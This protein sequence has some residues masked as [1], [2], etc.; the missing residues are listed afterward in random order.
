MSGKRRNSEIYMPES[1]MRCESGSEAST[2]SE[3]GPGDRAGVDILTI[4]RDA[5]V[6]FDLLLV[7]SSK[8]QRASAE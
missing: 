7:H 2:G 3:V 8:S 1:E 4:G 6:S 5:L